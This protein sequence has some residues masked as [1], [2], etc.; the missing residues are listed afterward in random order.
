MSNSPVKMEITALLRCNDFSSLI[1]LLSSIKNPFGVLQSLAYDQDEEIKWRAIKAVGIAAGIMAQ[2]NIEKVRD[3][4]RRLLWL[5]NDESGG[6][7]WHSP[8]MIGEILVNEPSLI[9]EYASLLV[10]FVNEEPFERGSHHAI[11]RVATVAPEA[12]NEWIEDLTESL[13]HSDIYIQ[14][15]S[16]LALGEIDPVRIKK[17]EG[18]F[19]GE[20]EKIRIFDFDT[21]QFE[22][23]DLKSV[24]RKVLDR[25]RASIDTA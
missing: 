12:F 11:Y 15:F 14:A 21:G 5:M 25:N 3:R 18:K 13:D 7:G 2:N 16:I 22:T 9:D 8:E 19:S 23:T 4:I 6:L 10:A 24:I 17:V 20:T 1:D